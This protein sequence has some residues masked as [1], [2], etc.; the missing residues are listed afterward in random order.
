MN[1]GSFGECVSCTEQIGGVGCP[2][3][4]D[5]SKTDCFPSAESQHIELYWC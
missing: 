4:V 5:N 3:V 2:G 1:Q